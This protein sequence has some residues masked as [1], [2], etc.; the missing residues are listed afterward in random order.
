MV[1]NP[2]PKLESLIK[3]FKNKIPRFPP[4]TTKLEPLGVRSGSLHIYKA[5]KVILRISQ[6]GKWLLQPTT[7]LVGG[8]VVLYPMH[9]ICN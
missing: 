5:P 1:H 8:L 2:N 6:V 3:L 9:F 7:P 4:W